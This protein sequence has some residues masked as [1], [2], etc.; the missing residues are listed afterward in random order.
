MKWQH[1][2]ILGGLGVIWWAREDAAPGYAG[3][4]KA[5]LTIAAYAA[6]ALGAFKVLELT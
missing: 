2:A 1:L 4:T 6:I 3:S 5:N